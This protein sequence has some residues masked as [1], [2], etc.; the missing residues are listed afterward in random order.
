[1]G[2]FIRFVYRC[3]CE[4]GEV[5]V[6]V[7]ICRMVE[8]REDEKMKLSAPT[9]IYEYLISTMMSSKVCMPLR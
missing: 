7:V 2:G 9:N 3:V 6:V 5:L 1:M 4:L 8:R